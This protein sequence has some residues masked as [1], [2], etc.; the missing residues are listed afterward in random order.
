MSIDLGLLVLRV[1]L[2]LIMLGH[3][4]QKL[5]GWFGGP[6]FKGFTGMLGGHMRL[7]PAAFWALMGGLSEAGGGLLFGLG[8]L[9][10]LGTLGLVAAMLMAI[11]IHW[12]KFAAN[13]GGYEYALVIL[14]AAL[15]VGITGPGAYS[16]DNWLGLTLPEPVT[17]IVGLVLVVAG[18][19]VAQASRRAAVEQP[20][21]VAAGH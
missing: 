19:I 3:G 17:L 2:G 16:L 4:S 12:P 1:A 11:Q 6:G 20:A 14:V 18:V 5:F 7:R 10:P 13:A 15:S 8:F 21:P 9:G